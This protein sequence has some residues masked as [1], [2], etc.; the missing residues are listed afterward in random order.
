MAVPWD[1][2]PE[3]LQ[4]SSWTQI[5]GGP[6]EYGEREEFRKTPL[7]PPKRDAHGNIMYEKWP[8]K[9]KNPQPLLDFPHLPDQIG[10]NEHWF[11]VE[12]WRRFEPRARW[13]DIAMRIPR[14]GRGRHHNNLQMEIS[15]NRSKWGLVS[16][17]DIKLHEEDNK[18]REKALAL[19]SPDQIRNNTTRGTT[20][21]LIN[22]ELG[23]A[24]GRIPNPVQARKRKSASAKAEEGSHSGDEYQEERKDNS[25]LNTP[26]KAKKRKGRDIVSDAKRKKQKANPLDEAIIE[27]QNLL[28]P[29][30][31]A[32]V[33]NM[34]YGISS[35]GKRKASH[36]F[37]DLEESHH[38]RSLKTARY[39]EIDSAASHAQPKEP[40]I[41][42]EISRS[43]IDPQLSAHSFITNGYSGGH[44]SEPNSSNL[45]SKQAPDFSQPSLLGNAS[46]NSVLQGAKR[47][48]N[49]NTAD[50]NRPSKI[51]RVNLLDG[52]EPSIAR[53]IK[54]P[55][56][57]VKRPFIPQTTRTLERN[58]AAAGDAG[59]FHGTSVTFSPGQEDT[60]VN[61]PTADG[62]TIDHASA[63]KEPPPTDHSSA[64]ASPAP[65]DVGA[66]GSGA[67]AHE[68]AQSI[69]GQ[70]D[71][72]AA[73]AASI[74]PSI[75]QPGNDANSETTH[76]YAQDSTFPA[77]RPAQGDGNGSSGDEVIN[78]FL[79]SLVDDSAINANDFDLYT[80]QDQLEGPG[81]QYGLGAG[82]PL[83]LH[84]TRIHPDALDPESL[85]SYPLCYPDI[86][87]AENSGLQTQQA[88]H[89]GS[90][91]DSG[92]SDPT[93]FD[94]S[95]LGF[96]F[97]QAPYYMPAEHS[98]L[99][100]NSTTFDTNNLDIQP[101]HLLDAD[102]TNLD[103][104]AWVNGGDFDL[105]NL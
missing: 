7:P 30:V 76:P 4:T 51:R 66:S 80:A 99:A 5:P 103:F 71:Q 104:N 39:Q 44:A 11:Y 27:H 101:D 77:M 40:H 6:A 55:Y 62:S 24:G 9:P 10:S 73:H 90:S 84:N 22:P 86:S 94:T 8:R 96:D 16:W 48:N 47:K 92:I 68:T 33:A 70:Q 91:D 42:E 35:P 57:Q 3:F 85:R 59:S 95:D 2:T 102:I 29:S 72:T 56:R 41:I 50:S 64:L 18:T 89:H 105:S 20:P 97:L 21:G 38:S 54:G 15:R 53:P 25:K 60:T 43:N 61:D 98:G 36:T 12:A 65:I 67:V 63:S 23:E 14:D 75:V 83:D 100:T 13:K 81:G 79:P 46:S 45:Q 1:Q 32:P 17:L 78:G 34:G 52:K 28:P 26:A 74:P 82:S 58:V 88:Q 37:D 19:L 87:E 49:D 31:A 69:A 93:I